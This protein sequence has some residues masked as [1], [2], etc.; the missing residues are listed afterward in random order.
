M[1][2][3]S[4]SS[5]YITLGNLKHQKVFIYTST[6]FLSKRISVLVQ[7]DVVILSPIILYIAVNG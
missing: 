1:P 5:K 7:A 3:N 6:S 2:L 4:G